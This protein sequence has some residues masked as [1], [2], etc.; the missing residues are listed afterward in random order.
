MEL[1]DELPFIQHCVFQIC[2]FFLVKI[3]KN[4]SEDFIHILRKMDP[5]PIYFGLWC[6]MINRTKLD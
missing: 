5:R 6:L 4:V 1:I 2:V 3:Y